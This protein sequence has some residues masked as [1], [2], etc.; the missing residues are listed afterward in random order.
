MCLVLESG[1]CKVVIVEEECF[2]V[3]MKGD[4]IVESIIEKVWL[5]YCLLMIKLKCIYIFFGNVGSDVGD[6]FSVVE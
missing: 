5:K 2:V 4:E 6:D 1:E 3:V